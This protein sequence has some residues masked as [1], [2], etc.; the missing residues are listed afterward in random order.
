MPMIRL[1]CDIFGDPTTGCQFGIWRATVS[2]QCNASA[3]STPAPHDAGKCGFT[4]PHFPAE[5]QAVT[6]ISKTSLTSHRCGPFLGPTRTN[7]DRS[8]KMQ[9]T[10]YDAVG[11][12]G[13]LND[14]HALKAAPGSFR[15]AGTWASPA[16]D[17]G[18]DSH[19][20]RAERR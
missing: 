19:G 13:W 6:A 15:R 5:T 20:R 7:P 12:L 8:C 9:Q 1:R 14:F 10:Q 18:V 3:R 17:K 16:C 4:D 11:G 2:L